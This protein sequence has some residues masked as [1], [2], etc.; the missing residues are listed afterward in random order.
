MSLVR[1]LTHAEALMSFQLGASKK[2]RAKSS[3]HFLIGLNHD[4]P[5]TLE[6]G[7]QSGG[8]YDGLIH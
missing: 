8:S 5:Y 6:M 3:N 4:G 2:C 1:D 7:T